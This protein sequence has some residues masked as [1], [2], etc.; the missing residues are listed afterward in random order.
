[1]FAELAA[2]LKLTVLPLPAKT[3]RVCLWVDR[4]GEGSR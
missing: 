2:A 1:M 3:L 4:K